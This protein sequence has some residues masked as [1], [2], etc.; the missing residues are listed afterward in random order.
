MPRKIRENH[1]STDKNKRIFIE[2]QEKYAILCNRL[3]KTRIILSSELKY[4]L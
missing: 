1:I 3:N 4:G 2:F